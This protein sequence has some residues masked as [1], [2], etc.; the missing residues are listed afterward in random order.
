MPHRKLEADSKRPGEFSVSPERGERGFKIKA[1]HE[2]YDVWQKDIDANAPTSWVDPEDGQTK[3]IRWIA[4]FGLKL[5]GKQEKDVFEDRVEAYTIE[6]DDEPGTKFVYFDGQSVQFF[7]NPKREKG[8]I[9][10]TL[11]LGDPNTGAMT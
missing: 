10:V 1:N 9:L 2:K 7:K 4:N 5:K 8:K 3:A 6:F 11:D